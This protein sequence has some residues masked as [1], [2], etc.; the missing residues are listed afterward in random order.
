MNTLLLLLIAGGTGAG[1]AVLLSRGLYYARVGRSRRR[2][3]LQQLT[4]PQAQPA[5]AAAQVARRIEIADRLLPDFATELVWAELRGVTLTREELLGYTVMTTLVGIAVGLLLLG[6]PGAVVGL[7]GFYLPYLWLKSQAD[8]ARNQ[9]HRQ[10]PEMLQV[11]AAETATGVGLTPALERLA[12]SHSMVGRV[13]TR[14]LTAA[15]ARPGALWSQPTGQAGA[16]KQLAREWRAETL[17]SLISQLEL[18]QRRGISGPETMTTLA[19]GM[20]LRF[21]GAARTQADQLENRLVLPLGLFFFAPFTAATIAP[22]I[23]M[24]TSIF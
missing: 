24:L 12:Q 22:L 17:L 4:H 19:R 5:S 3:L 21:L 7:A 11:L 13:F 15:R 8:A 6:L 23:T 10:L 1:T 18:V 2:R 20:S 9:F 14:L 16:L